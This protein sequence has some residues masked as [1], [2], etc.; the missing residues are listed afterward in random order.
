MLTLAV[1]SLLLAS[2]PSLMTAINLRVLARGTAPLPS[3]APAAV[4]VLIPARNEEAGIGACVAAAL[5]STGVDLEVIVL[6]D[7]SA[8][9]TAAIVSRLAAVDPRVRLHAAPPL[10]PGWSGKQHACHAL[11]TLARKPTLVFVD[12]D[13]RLEPRAAA[14]LAAAL[15]HADLVSGVPRQVMGSTVE[16]MLIAMI[17]TMLL[18]YLPI[19]LMRRDKR[20]ALGAGCGQMMA[21]R[22]DSYAKAGGHA[23]IRHSLHDG[24]LLPRL[25]RS[26]G[27]LTDLVAGAELAS[28]RMYVGAAATIAGSLKNAT[29]GIAKPVALPIWTVLLLGGHLLPWLVLPAALLAGNGTAA[30][31]AAPACAG[32][33]L[34]HLAQ[35]VRCREPLASV[36][37][38]PLSVALLV[39]V[40]WLALLRQARGRPSTWRGRTYPARS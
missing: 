27:L 15:G 9:A 22:A 38:H 19:P 39:G 17:N 20:P 25:F 4:S 23:G 32:P 34:A 37:L 31:V 26:A 14:G 21:V 2:L 29:E 33:M 10:P 35:A 16:M 8:D 18:G 12:A 1:V 40:Q 11:A 28:C 13:V 7:H 30:A 24:L 6:D 36:L 5:A 3:G